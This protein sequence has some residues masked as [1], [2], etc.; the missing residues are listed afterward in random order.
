LKASEGENCDFQ[1]QVYINTSFLR[2]LS[3]FL[4]IFLDLGVFLKRNR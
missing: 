4:T 3:R 2:T 1:N